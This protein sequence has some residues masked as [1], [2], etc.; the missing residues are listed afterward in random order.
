MA[1]NE[2]LFAIPAICEGVSRP[3]LVARS[4][5]VEGVK[6]GI[7]RHVPANIYLAHGDFPR[8]TVFKKVLEIINFFGRREPGF[9]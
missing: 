9:V 6:A 4:G 7:Y 1:D 5:E 3:N 8:G 2:P